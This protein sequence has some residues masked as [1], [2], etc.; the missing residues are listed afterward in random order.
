MNMHSFTRQE[1][2]ARKSLRTRL[3]RGALLAAF[4][5]SLAGCKK[6]PSAAQLVLEQFALNVARA[7]PT[8]G[9]ILDD[10]TVEYDTTGGEPADGT[11]YALSPSNVG[12]V[13][14]GRGMLEKET[15]LASGDRR[16][17]L[18]FNLCLRAENQT[19]CVRPSQYRYRALLRQEN[20][21][22]KVAGSTCEIVWEVR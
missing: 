13:D 5:M 10:G 3:G 6:D 4:T 1:A 16:V 19:S 7:Q 18:L 12:V 2:R 8:E 9:L 20:G 17:D 11:I 21:A 22:W 15:V 14:W